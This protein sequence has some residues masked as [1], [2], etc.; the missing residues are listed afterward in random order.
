MLGFGGSFQLSE[1]LLRVTPLWISLGAIGLGFLLVLITSI[2]GNRLFERELGEEIQELTEMY[3]SEIIK[4]L[5]KD[6]GTIENIAFEKES[7]YALVTVRYTVDGKGK[8]TRFSHNP[9]P[10]A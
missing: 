5:Q 4:I 6:F 3:Q 8:I 1:V 9:A 2:W 7:D 10:Q